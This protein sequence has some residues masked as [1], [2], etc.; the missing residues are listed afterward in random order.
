MYKTGNYTELSIVMY[1]QPQSWANSSD[2]GISHSYLRL[3]SSYYI[4]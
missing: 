2:V 4:I 1:D 3:W